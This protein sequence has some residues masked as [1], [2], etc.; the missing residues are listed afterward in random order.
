MFVEC[1]PRILPFSSGE[2]SLGLRVPT[3]K[4]LGP[5]FS[6]GLVQLGSP[7]SVQALRIPVP[8]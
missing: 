3:E 2:E 1:V 8:T 4:P 5:S 6:R 7:L